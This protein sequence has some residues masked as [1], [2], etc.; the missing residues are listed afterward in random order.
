M[1]AKKGMDKNKFELYLIGSLDLLYLDAKD[2]IG[3]HVLIKIGSL[4]V[5]MS[6]HRGPF[7]YSL[8]GSI[9]P[10]QSIG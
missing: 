5:C 3:K 2:T 6:G 1:N 8:L 7:A 10:S 4:S 9:I